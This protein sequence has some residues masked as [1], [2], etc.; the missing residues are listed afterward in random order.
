MF[1]VHVVS[2]NRSEVNAITQVDCFS[3]DGI[4]EDIDEEEFRGVTFTV[5][6]IKFN[7]KVYCLPIESL[8]YSHISQALFFKII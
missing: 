8:T 6:W 7:D 4:G 3:S 5:Q 2:S 1:T